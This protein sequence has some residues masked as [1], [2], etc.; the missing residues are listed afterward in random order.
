[1]EKMETELRCSTSAIITKKN[2]NSAK[3]AF[4]YVDRIK[5]QQQIEERK[6]QLEGIVTTEHKHWL[7]LPGS[8]KLASRNPSGPAA[9]NKKMTASRTEEQEL[10]HLQPPFF[11]HWG[12]VVGCS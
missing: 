6:L 8:G 11:F 5:H 12:R 3:P 4:E 2:C 9:W 1:M 7:W 10:Q